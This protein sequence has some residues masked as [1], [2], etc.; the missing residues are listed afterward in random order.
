MASHDAAALF[1]SARVRWM[2]DSGR[3]QRPAKGVVVR[4]SGALTPLERVECE[5]RL[6]H[7][8][9]A[10][11]GL[12]AAALDGLK[13]FE[14]ATVFMLMPHGLWTR[15]RSGVK[16]R[17]VRT[18]DEVDVH[19]VRTPRRTRIARSIVDAASWAPSELR[20]AAI[21]ASGVQQGLVTTTALRFVVD[22]L[23]KLPHR[24]LILETV[25]DVSGGSLSEYEVLF[26]RLCRR[27]KF[28]VPTRQRRRR[29]SS[30]RWR[31]LD[32]DF[33][34]YCLVVEIDGQQHMAALAWWEDM[35]RNNELVVDEKKALL[36]FSGFALR[37]EPDRVAEVLRRFFS[38]RT[39]VDAG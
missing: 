38:S 3:W 30:G 32:I 28:P 13:G 29:D 14:S 4:H 6:Q 5:I 18:L 17:R 8:D 7:P 1:G 37:H 20:C 27:Y 21:I 23:P 36:R 2:V 24:A 15:R 26:V 25:R 16:V 19:P 12:T 35:M 10:L 11:A 34:E 22:R 9:A 33:D 39:P 31:Y